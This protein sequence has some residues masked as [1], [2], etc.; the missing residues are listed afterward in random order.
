MAKPIKCDLIDNCS[1]KIL[2]LESRS[3]LLKYCKENGIKPKRSPMSSPNCE[4]WYIEDFT[5]LPTGYLD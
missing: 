1:H 2:K 5:Y 3:A 4:S